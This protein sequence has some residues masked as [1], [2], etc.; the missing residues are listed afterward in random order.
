MVTNT[1]IGKLI[2]NRYQINSRVGSGG[3]ARVYRAHDTLMGR[4]VAL[5]IL[6]EDE[7]RYRINSRSFETE[8]EAISKLSHPNIVTIY[9]VSMQGN[10]NYIVMEY[11]EGITLR[12]YLNFH[13]HLVPEE[14]FSC[15]K[16]IL[17][18]LEAAHAKGIIH[19]DIKPQNV[20]ILKTSGQIKVADF[21]I[22]RLP[23]TDNFKLDDRAIGTVHYISPEQATGSAVDERSDLY[24]LG[25]LMYEMLT[26]SR[27][28]EA[29]DAST[30]A[31]MQV[32]DQ[33]AAPRTLRDDIPP[34]LEQVIMRAMRKDPDE[35]YENATAMLRALI[36]AE[37]HPTS[38]FKDALSGASRGS[39]HHFADFFG[40]F[41]GRRSVQAEEPM[42]IDGIEHEEEINQTEDDDMNVILDRERYERKTKRWG[43]NG[44]GEDSAD[45]SVSETIEEELPTADEEDTVALADSTAVDALEK[46]EALDEEDDITEESVEIVGEEI[47]AEEEPEVE[48]E[49]EEELEE[50]QES[51]EA[52]K[53]PEDDLDVPDFL[54]SRIDATVARENIAERSPE[55]ETAIETADT[56]LFNAVAA[57]RTDIEHNDDEEEASDADEEVGQPQEEEDIEFSD[58]ADIGSEEDGA[59]QDEQATELDQR[60]AELEEKQSELD[61]RLAEYEL[62]NAKLDARAAEADARDAE[63]DKK[64]AIISAKDAEADARFAEADARFAEAEARA[65]EV[66]ARFA[67]LEAMREAEMQEDDMR[68]EEF[69]DESAPAKSLMLLKILFPVVSGALAIGLCFVLWYSG[70]LFGRYVP[71]VDNY[72]GASKISGMDVVVEYVSDHSAV[73][74]VLS[75]TPAAGFTRKNTDTIYL[76]VSAGR[77]VYEK[78]KEILDENLKGDLASALHFLDFINS[79]ENNPK[80]RAVKVYETH[81]TVK[82]GEIIRYEIDPI[83]DKNGVTDILI[84]VSIGADES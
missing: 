6:E 5:K 80:N 50:E 74:T 7:T 39:E 56:V 49:A 76:R 35:R 65:Q 14:V 13:T 58:E 72:Q 48:L 17:A 27:P 62:M 55:D 64:Q 43:K 29:S 68:D 44:Q 71:D 37:K 77:S 20:M 52:S 22:A 40:R 33:P 23:D 53:E 25:I 60:Q 84:Y 32:S 46:P 51:K 1:Y 66:D 9:D 73:G 28:F 34:A 69:T 8:V 45:I 2:D 11:V 57:E 79:K 47:V 21:G 18:A 26:G 82:A 78:Y 30:V 41:F 31:M 38:T 10:V 12:E 67:E 70:I 4:T 24:S 3:S 81:D 83:M 19:R 75:Q 61:E 63:L 36:R 59:E 16:Q 54:Q 15:A 42:T